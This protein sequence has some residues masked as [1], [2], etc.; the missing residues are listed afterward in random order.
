M[1]A[2]VKFEEA[3]KAIKDAA[4]DL[5]SLEVHTYVGD[6]DVVVKDAGDSTNFDDILSS[7]KTSGK[8]KLAFVT[9]IEFDGDAKVL[10]PTA[11]APDHIQQ[12][13]SAAVKAGQDIRLGLL[14]LFSEMTGL[15]VTKP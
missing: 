15:R 6:L 12:A 10:V 4:C 7:G 2:K 8:L 3:L 1:G 5:T 11:A 9:K 14:S 13:H